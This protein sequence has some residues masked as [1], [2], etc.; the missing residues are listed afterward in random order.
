MRFLL[1]KLSHFFIFF[2]GLSVTAPFSNLFY[3]NPDD[4][5]YIAQHDTAALLPLSRFQIGLTSCPWGI[6]AHL[7]V[8]PVF[9]NFSPP[10]EVG[11]ILAYFVE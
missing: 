7:C 9:N 3:S 6:D 5:S 4:E 8:K 11:G 1:T 2:L 10:A